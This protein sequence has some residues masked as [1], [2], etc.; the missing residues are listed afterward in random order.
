[1]KGRVQLVDFGQAFGVVIDY[2]HT[3]EA[4]RNLLVTMRSITKGRVIVIFG[5]GGNRDKMKRP[6]MG[7]I[8]TQFSDF[9]VITSDNPRSENPDNIIEMIEKGVVEDNW[10]SITNR[11][12][13]INWAIKK[14]RPGDMVV[15]AGKGHEDYQIL[16]DRTIHFDDYE[17]VKSAIEEFC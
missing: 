8:A 12:E 6:V 2:A 5:A 1:M 15:I 4:L 3:P 13:A 16:Q 7:R 14:A 17:I 10:K 9:A 11:K